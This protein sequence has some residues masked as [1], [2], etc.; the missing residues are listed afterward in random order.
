MSF[1]V[2][3][4]HLGAQGIE[5]I[6][7]LWN[8]LALLL[9]QC[10]PSHV[11][12]LIVSNRI[13]LFLYQVHKKIPSGINPIY[14]RLFCETLLPVSFPPMFDMG[15]IFK[16]CEGDLFLVGKMMNREITF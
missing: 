10:G 11:L 13:I 8:C 16:E 3:D 12:A 7:E 9:P 2:F 4:T 15:E 6:G 1:E 5:G 14:S